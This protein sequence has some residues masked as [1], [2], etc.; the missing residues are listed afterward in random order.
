M[1]R[2]LRLLGIQL[3]ASLLLMMQYRVEPTVGYA[4][5]CPKVTYVPV[6]SRMRLLADVVVVRAGMLLD[7]LD[8]EEWPDKEMDDYTEPLRKALKEYD[9]YLNGLE[10]E[11]RDES[12][13][14]D[15]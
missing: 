6:E 8:E 13:S 7:H 9:A 1:L 4:R 2:Y 14:Q 15:R 12:R 5:W 10:K 11:E 3:R